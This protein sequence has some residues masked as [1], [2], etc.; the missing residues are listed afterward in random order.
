MDKTGQDRGSVFK[1]A[2]V[3]YVYCGPKDRLN[4]ILTVSYARCAPRPWRML[5]KILIDKRVAESPSKTFERP[6]V[7]AR[8]KTKRYLK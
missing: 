6:L 3:S 7:L 4:N 1:H 2:Q 8:C 5:E